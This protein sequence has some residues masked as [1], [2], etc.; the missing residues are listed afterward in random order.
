MGGHAIGPARAIG[1]RSILIL[2]FLCVN[3][4]L[5][6]ALAELEDGSTVG[7][8]PYDM[9]KRRDRDDVEEVC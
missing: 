2:R 8:S 7:L 3:L 9:Q 6:A 4:L 5:R 1:Q